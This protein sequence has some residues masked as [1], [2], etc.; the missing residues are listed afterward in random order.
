VRKPR[1]RKIK[2]RRKLALTR[3]QTQ[4]SK[5]TTGNTI[6]GSPAPAK[7]A[8]IFFSEIPANKELNASAPTFAR[9]AGG[10]TLWPIVNTLPDINSPFNIATWTDCLSRYPDQTL[11][12]D[13]LHDIHSGVN[14]GF[15]GN[16]HS[17]IY[18]NHLSATTNLEAVARE[19]ERELS[20]NRKIGPFLTPPFANFVGS[21][22]GAIPKKRS[23]PTKWRII[24][25]LS[26]P[27]AHSINDGIPKELFSCTYDS[28]D[29]AISQLKL[30]GQGALMSKLDLSD[31][32]RHILVRREDWELL[33]ST[34]PIDINGTVTTAYFVDAFL[35]FGLRSSPALFLKYVDILSFTMRD[36]GARPVWNY[37]DDFWTCGPPAPDPLC[38][39]NLDIM[40]NTCADLGFNSNPAK[41]VVP[42]TTLELLGI[43]L[44]S[45]T[46]EARISQT[47]L[48]ETLDL[49]QTWQTKASCTKRQLQ[50]LIGKLN[51]ICSV[52]RPGRTF[53]R[54]MLELLSK[55]SHPSHHIRL[56][57]R[58]FKDIEW[59]LAF[60]S[61]WNGRSM[62]Y[63]EQWL[64]NVCL[65]LFTDAC[66]E[67]FGALFG[68]AWLSATFHDVG[69]PTRRSI[70]YKELYA[71]TMAITV[72]A[73]SLASQNVL[74]HCDNQSV[75]RIL[76]SG[77]SKCRHI[78]SLVRYLFFICSKF[79]IVLRAVHIPGILN[80]ASDALS[81]LQVQRF[82]KLVPDADLLPTPVLPLNLADFK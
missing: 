62:F 37:L 50:S 67:S 58:F 53:L 54:R 20:L 12:N 17:Q 29:H 36:R 32:F 33:G 10:S 47:R 11:A 28:L 68:T 30:H 1:W 6:N 66:A 44:D 46:Q 61:D 31:A 48:D 38:Q 59:W 4:A 9:L 2:A 49:L 69:I 8:A 71:I 3:A 56:N 55:G 35:P 72:W 14:I 39:T 19:L 26:W 40:L 52:C 70:T 76:T 25:D 79:N 34:W 81:R 74:F 42:C 51:F 15:S 80:S 7:K 43:E 45:V 63:D 82:R 22:M 27:A 75:V 60:L 5:L 41:T 77:S 65:H 13:L 64:S 23:M 73:P 24:H 18:D 16:R 21:P 57:K 78:M